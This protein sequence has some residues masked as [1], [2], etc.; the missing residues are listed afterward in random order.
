MLAGNGVRGIGMLIVFVC[1]VLLIADPA[2]TNFLAYGWA[3]PV[4]GHI[5]L[6]LALFFG[7]S[8]YLIGRP[9][10]RAYVLGTR[11]P[12]VRRFL[13][14][15]L[16]RVV[17]AF[18][19][20]A[21]L[22]LLRFGLDGS[23]GSGT[24]PPEGTA[25]H[26][27]HSSLLQVLGIYAFVQAQ[28][29]GPAAA[30]IGQAWSLGAEMAFYALVPVAAFFA[31][32]LGARLA[33]PHTRVAAALV[34][35]V[36]ASLVSIWL[37]ARDQYVFAWLT[38][39]PAMLYAFLPGIGVALVEPLLAP[40]LR[41]RAVLGRRLALGIFAFAAVCAVVYAA[42]DYSAQTTAIH[43]AVGRRALLAAVFTG[44]LLLGLVVLQLGTR[45][46]PWVL[47]NRGMVW[48]GERSYSFYLVHVWVLLEIGNVLDKAHGT[49]TT[50][51]VM[52]GVGTP[53]SI[54][55]ASLSYRFVERPFLE[56]KRQTTARSGVPEPAAP[57]EAPAVGAVA[58][59]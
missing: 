5:D 55:L 47:A 56:R 11:R 30:P 24:K 51:A 57:S 27:G 23:L 3:A 28:V 16:L 34:V 10:V 21:T 20:F 58:R 19:L 32:R 14:N 42:S 26:V 54:G 18:Y 36:V 59:A 33:R 6:A 4:L 17:P 44:A 25:A 38:S 40:R 29:D 39:P 50:A 53:V 12:S 7:L 31:Y 48:M 35:V 37:R 45:R 49:F 46:G 8:G 43:H 52:F 1:H 15:R 22:I 9:F 41:D 13:A 2:E